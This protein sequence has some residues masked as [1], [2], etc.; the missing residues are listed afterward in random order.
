MAKG[1]KVP[2][3]TAR[4]FGNTNQGTRGVNAG[5]DAGMAAVDAATGGKGDAAI[6]LT[7]G[8]KSASDV[9]SMK[10]TY[11]KTPGHGKFGQG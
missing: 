2:K 5:M 8:K 6:G 1:F 4:P 7:H 9:H 10:N 3:K 11:G